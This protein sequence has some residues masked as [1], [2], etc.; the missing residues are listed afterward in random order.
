[1]NDQKQLLTLASE[2][3]KIDPNLKLYGNKFYDQVS[4]NEFLL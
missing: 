1:M 2:V 3:E 4:V